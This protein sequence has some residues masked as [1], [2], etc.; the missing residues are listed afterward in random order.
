MFSFKLNFKLESIL[1]IDVSFL[2][3]IETISKKVFLLFLVI[4]FHKNNFKV[5]LSIRIV[6]FL[7]TNYLTNIVY[8][9]I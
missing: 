7:I 5:I 9:P 8:Y 6:I 3:F 1:K 2:K 4:I